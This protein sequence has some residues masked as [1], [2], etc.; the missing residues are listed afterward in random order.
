ML[1]LICSLLSVVIHDIS[2]IF[3]DNIDNIGEGILILLSVLFSHHRYER[4]VEIGR[5][6]SEDGCEI[7]T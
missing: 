7:V 5:S 2:F 4:R 3:F 6:R 1:F